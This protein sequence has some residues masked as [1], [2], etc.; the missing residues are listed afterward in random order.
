MNK[1]KPAATNIAAR[2]A[3]FG[4]PT[5]VNEE[6]R[7]VDFTLCTG[8]SVRVFDYD[9]WSVI[10]ESLA[11][12]GL[13][14]PS[15]RNQVPLL[16]THDSSSVQ[17]IFGSV[18]NIRQEQGGIV[19][20]L[21]FST[22]DSSARAFELVK[23]G[24]L[25]DGSIGY[26]VKKYKNIKEGES[27]THNGAVYE[28]AQRLVTEFE[29]KEFSLAPIGADVGAVSRN[30][31]PQ[32]ELF[33]MPEITNPNEVK[34]AERAE[35]KVVS[36]DTKALEQEA[37]TRAV[38]FVT[39]VRNECRALGLDDTAEA[40][41]M[42]FDTLEAARAAMIE[43][44]AKTTKPINQRNIEIVADDGTKFR[45][46]AVDG[47][48][49]RAGLK[50]A[51]P[52]AGAESL[53]F[54]FKALAR[55][56]VERNNINTRG[57]SDERIFELALR[58]TM[59]YQSKSDFSN[60]LLDASNK[61]IMLGWQGVKSTYEA[62]C[63]IGSVSDFKTHNR[64]RLSDAP[65]MVK[66]GEN[67]ELQRKSFSDAG[68]TVSADT[69]GVVFGISRQA[70]IDDDLGVFNTIP[71]MIGARA[72]QQINA[73]AY[74]LLA[75]NKL[76][77]GTTA[78]FSSG[79]GNLAAS[80]AAPS[81]TTLSAA[82]IALMKQTDI[83]G[84]KLNIEPAFVICGANNADNV[85]IMLSSEYLPG[86]ENAKNPFYNLAQPIIDANITGNEWY[87]AANP[88]FPSIEIVF[89]NGQQTPTIEELPP[90]EVLG[91][92]M[93]AYLDWGGSILDFRGLYKNPGQ[94]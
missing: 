15:G 31:I 85:I 50:V 93:R 19:G 9:S 76:S 5:T 12:D 37:K 70:L 16:D 84:T 32:K 43:K 20:T 79:N 27:Y 90:T 45:A 24:H 69:Y 21:H 26:I 18:K 68:A 71:L 46:A 13:R 89:L 44:V 91:M 86:N 6:Q 42:A 14:L 49:L 94:A 80:G 8:N 35:A 59:P 66:V 63:K 22:D 36:V 10:K 1:N 77:D 56:C 62:F 53:R 87:V 81:A 61:A 40:E 48:L 29:L 7:S 57:M 3:V 23:Q 33:D 41:I 88:I 28:G 55:E 11:L 30:L 17:N 25:T 58:S 60:V 78:C 54:G 73:F 74:D 75:A 52:A 4:A 83:N 72:R 82:R 47:M 65:T 38:Q 67:G 92:T 51:T 64:V 34:P 2:S 39:T